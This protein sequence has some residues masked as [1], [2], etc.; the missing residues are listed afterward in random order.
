MTRSPSRST[1]AEPGEDAGDRALAE[2]DEPRRLAV[3]RV[4]E[5]RAGAALE[6][7]LR[8]VALPGQAEPDRPHGALALRDP[9]DRLR[10]C[11]VLRDDD[12]RAAAEHDRGAGGDPE[13][14]E[15]DRRAS[16]TQPRA[17][18]PERV[19]GGAP[20]AHVSATSSL[21]GSDEAVAPTRLALTQGL[22]RRA[23]R[24]DEAPRAEFPR[25]RLDERQQLVRRHGP[26]RRRRAPLQVA[27][28]RPGRRRR[29]AER[30]QERRERRRA[31][32]ARRLVGDPHLERAEARMGPGVPPAARVVDASRRDR[33]LPLLRRAEERRLAGAG[34]LEQSRRARRQRPR[35]LA[36]EPGRVEREGEHRR[37]P[38]HE[39]VE[40]LQ[41]GVEALHPDVDMESA[42][43]LAARGRPHLLEHLQIARLGH[44]CLL[45]RPGEGMRPARR[46]DEPLAPRGLADDGAQQDELLVRALAPSRKPACWSRR[47]RRRARSSAPPGRAAAPLRVRGRTS[48]DR[49][50]AAPPRRRSSAGG[51]T[52]FPRTAWTGRPAASHA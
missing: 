7:R 47:G 33:G 6:E 5:R 35:L 51:R 14:D 17:D 38:R 11:P 34:Q 15:E 50:A 49:R 13:H 26:V 42:D 1:A 21:G 29:G 23:Q 41:A 46:D 19:E 12:A 3:H 20:G 43:E 40:R 25:G 39:R 8:L 16:S 37:E 2:E 18:E 36:L 52:Y 10:D 31:V 4:A 48:P 9:L 30:L 24:L 22:H 28:P 32:D 45:L 44:D 27:V